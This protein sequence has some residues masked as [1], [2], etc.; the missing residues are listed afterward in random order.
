M[1][2]PYPL[3]YSYDTY[4]NALRHQSSLSLPLSLL[5]EQ[6]YQVVALR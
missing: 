4:Y 5:T 6:T 3:T 2:T 1:A